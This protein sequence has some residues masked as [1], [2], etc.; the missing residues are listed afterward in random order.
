LTTVF[1]DVIKLSFKDLVEYHLNSCFDGKTEK[2]Q[3][4]FKLCDVEGAQK[5][6][7]IRQNIK[8]FGVHDGVFLFKNDVASTNDNIDMLGVRSNPNTVNTLKDKNM[9]GIWQTGNL[10]IQG[11]ARRTREHRK[12]E[13]IRRVYLIHK[14]LPGSNEFE[15]V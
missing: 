3:L 5:A 10:S 2:Y 12:V 8:N 6:G 9:E 11:E 4:Y 15:S 14:V 7:L 13:K 1:T